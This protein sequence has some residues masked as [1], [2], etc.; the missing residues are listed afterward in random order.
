MRLF[1]REKNPNEFPPLSLSSC[2]GLVPLQDT[3]KGLFTE[4]SVVAQSYGREN[5][6]VW[7]SGTLRSAFS[8][9]SQPLSQVASE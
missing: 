4:E 6:L 5:R 8:S 3:H 1:L 7:D 9:L 2:P